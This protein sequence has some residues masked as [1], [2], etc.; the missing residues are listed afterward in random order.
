MHLIWLN[1]I[2]NL[3]LLF[4]GNFKE[5]PLDDDYFLQQSVWEA[6]GVATAESGKT[7]P[8]A[9][10]ARVPNI[11]KEKH[12]FTAETWSFWSLYL[13]PALLHRRFQNAAYYK[14]FLK[15][16]KLI[17][18][19][20]QFE[21]S[22]NEVAQLRT[23]FR[24]WVTEFESLYYKSDPERLS[25]C[26]VT[27]H[28]LL[29]IADSIETSGPVWTAWAFVM[30]RYCGS[31]RPAIRSRRF[32]FASMDTYVEEKA[33]LSQVKLVYNLG[34]HLALSPQASDV[35]KGEYVCEAYPK[36]V[37][38]P[39]KTWQAL[40]EV[41][42]LHHKVA[43]CLATRFNVSISVAKKVVPVDAIEQW[44]KVRR[45]DGGD[46]MHAR[47]LVPLREGNRDASFV[48][49]QLL[50]DTHAR[51]RRLEAHFEVQ[52]FFGQLHRIIVLRLE[53]S[54]DIK[55]EQPVTLFLAAI[56]R[57][58]ADIVNIDGMRYYKDM[59]DVEVVDLASVQCVIGRVKTPSGLW[60]IIDRSG[61]MANA[62]FVSEW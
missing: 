1:L 39:P 45:I 2:P 49:Y 28:G 51:N 4:T 54:N 10:G 23:G 55:L 14:H 15:L 35:K 12:Y 27:V 46:T 53:P 19:C 56:Q 3:V 8:S 43:A 22:S 16:V 62:E 32:P 41:P 52:N 25:T 59:G 42:R 7:V 20:L 34:T 13:A 48:R 5:V 6:I 30:E 17:H 26:P 24:E 50:V 58:K 36:C 60:G 61:P 38:M 57:A 44:G 31:L 18:I 33:Q 11:A 21:I 9:F 37:L 29:H 47:E 40:N